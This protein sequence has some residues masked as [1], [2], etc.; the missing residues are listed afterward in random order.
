MFSPRSIT[1]ALG[2]VRIFCRSFCLVAV[3]AIMIVSC[4]TR[5]TH[6]NVSSET[7]FAP[8]PIA[9]DDLTGTNG[10]GEARV[11]VLVDKIDIL[12]LINPDKLE[13]QLQL[14]EASTVVLGKVDESTYVLF[15]QNSGS[16]LEYNIHTDELVLSIDRIALATIFNTTK[17]QFSSLSNLQGDTWIFGF[18]TSEKS[19]FVMRKVLKI[20]GVEELEVTVLANIN[21]IRRQLREQSINFIKSAEVGTRGSSGKNVSEILMIASPP[22]GAGGTEGIESVH[23][24]IVTE[25][26]DDITGG[27]RVFDQNGTP[28]FGFTDESGNPAI[29]DNEDIPFFDQFGDPIEFFGLVPYVQVQA[30]TQSAPIDIFDYDPAVIR[31]PAE[32]SVRIPL[33]KFFLLYENTSDVFVINEVIRENN[34][35]YQDFGEIIASSTNLYSNFGEVQTAIR[36]GGAVLSG[37]TTSL[38]FDTSFYHPEHP[39]ILAFEE[40]TN[41]MME[42]DYTAIDLDYNINGDLFFGS[43]VGVFSPSSNL[44]D[45]RDFQ[46]KEDADIAPQEPTFTISLSDVSENRMVFDQGTDDIISINYNTGIYVVVIKQVDIGRATGSPGVSDLTYIDPLTAN[47]IL[48]MDT[49][50]SDLLLVRVDY[51]AFP[52]RTSSD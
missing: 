23:L 2:A 51:A 16:L 47:G 33:P 46:S 41:N 21:S 9:V 7:F 4:D 44:V 28:Y 36:Q 5:S 38:K 6:Q 45:R 49:P 34:A 14:E 31:N 17:A 15:E 12:K 27:F 29:P 13:S 30:V 40:E 35:S 25:E 11:E 39:I 10:Q 48:A 52:V 32:P 20:G 37:D 43:R 8:V 3:T 19:L 50:A 1:P 22:G 26:N 42:L 18:E 24:F